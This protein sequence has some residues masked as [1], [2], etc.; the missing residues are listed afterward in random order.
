MGVHDSSM[1]TGTGEMPIGAK[2]RYEMQ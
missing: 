2:S 1:G